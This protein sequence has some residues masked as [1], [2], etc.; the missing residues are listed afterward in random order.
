MEGAERK[1]GKSLRDATLAALDGTSEPLSITEYRRAHHVISENA[2]SLAFATALNDDDQPQI[3]QLMRQAH[4]SMQV[5]FEASCPEL[6][7]MAAAAWATS[8]VIGAR[9]TGGGFGGACV[10]LVQCEEADRVLTEVMQRYQATSGGRGD[11]ILTAASD[12]ARTVFAR[13]A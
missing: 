6:D 4:R 2:R 8:G 5:D 12:G 10:G 9:V 13:I 11:A 1:L 3:G 7:A